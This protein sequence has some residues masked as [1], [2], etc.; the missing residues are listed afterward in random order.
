MIGEEQVGESQNMWQFLKRDHRRATSH[1][2]SSSRA[3]GADFGEALKRA[4]DE[5]D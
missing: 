3:I 1:L 5:L 2:E 4:L